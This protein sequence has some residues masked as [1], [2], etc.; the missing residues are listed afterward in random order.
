MLFRSRLAE[1]LT[2]LARSG[3]GQLVGASGAERREY[4]DSARREYAEL[5]KELLGSLTTPS[6]KNAGLYVDLADGQ[7]LEP[8]RVHGEAI[9]QILELGWYLA[10]F[11]A[12]P[13]VMANDQAWEAFASR[14]RRDVCDDYPPPRG[15]RETSESN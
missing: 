13:D 4:E 12:L 6:L 7:L 10:E 14:V 5:E 8:D 9:G 15:S 3:V 2:D 1:Y 11:G